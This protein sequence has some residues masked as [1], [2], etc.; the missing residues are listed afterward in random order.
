MTAQSN[1][2]VLKLVEDYSRQNELKAKE[3]EALTEK[4]K[5]KKDSMTV[6]KKERNELQTKYQRV[7]SK[8]QNMSKFSHIFIKSIK[9]QNLS[10]RDQVQKQKE[11]FDEA[12]SSTCK[13]IQQQINTRVAQTQAQ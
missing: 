7:E 6:L 1:Q 13:V 12:F 3:I 8:L 9:Q 10:L 2:D 11:D 4:L 5:L